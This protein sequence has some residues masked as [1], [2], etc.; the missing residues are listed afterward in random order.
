MLQ[1]NSNERQESR[2]QGET[3]PIRLFRAGSVEG[4][5]RSW[6]NLPSLS[7][8][9]E[10]LEAGHVSLPFFVV[11]AFGAKMKESVS[12]SGRCQAGVWDKKA[13]HPGTTE[14]ESEYIQRDRPGFIGSPVIHSVGAQYSFVPLVCLSTRTKHL[15]QKVARRIIK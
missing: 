7:T 12:D 1:K 2:Q 9:P 4:G 6:G 5:L 10:L 13:P 11:L 15:P 14:P 3:D 8:W